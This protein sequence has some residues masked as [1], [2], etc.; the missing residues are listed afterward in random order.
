MGTGKRLTRAVVALSLTGLMLGSAG[1]AS[2]YSPRTQ[3]VAASVQA[4]PLADAGLTGTLQAGKWKKVL[5][6][7]GWY[8]IGYAAYI[9]APGG[10]VDCYAP[11]WPWPTSYRTPATIWHNVNG[12]GDCWL[13]SPVN[14]TY[15]LKPVWG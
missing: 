3:P 15:S 13:Y 10:K 2:A 1:T 6:G 11:P 5:W 7:W 8:S 12:Y 9:S 14:A 4:L